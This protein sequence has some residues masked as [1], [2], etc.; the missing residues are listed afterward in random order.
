[1]PDIRGTVSILLAGLLAGWCCIAPVHARPVEL[2]TIEAVEAHVGAG[3]HAEALEGYRLLLDQA[4]G[5]E[6]L[7]IAVRLAE[8]A[9]ATGQPHLALEALE[10]HLTEAAMA[11]PELFDA[12]QELLVEAASM[13]GRQDMAISAA[14]RLVAFRRDTWGE[15]A[16][17]LQAGRLTLSGLLDQQGQHDEARALRDEAFAVLAKGDPELYLR[18]LNNTAIVL[19][20]GG[21]LDEAAQ[22]FARLIAALEEDG[23]SLSLGITH[24]NAAILDRDRRRHD[25]AIDHHRRAIEILEA[26][27]GPDSAHAIAAIGGLGQTYVF[28]GRPASAMPLLR[29]ALERARRALGDSDD[30]MLQAN[31]LA[32]VLRTLGRFAE[33]EPLDREAYGWREANL[34]P[35]HPATL[36]SRKNLA[37]DL[38]GLDRPDEAQTYYDAIVATLEGTRGPDH[39]LT[40][41]MRLERDMIAAL[42]GTAPAEGFDLDAISDRAEPSGDNVLLAN[43]LAGIAGRRG[44][45]RTE[46]ALNRLSL[47][48]ADAWHGPYHPTTLAMLTNVARS[49]SALDTEESFATYVELERRLRIWSRREFASTSD[50]ATLEQVATTT[51]ENIGDIMRYSFHALRDNPQVMQLVGRLLVEWKTPGSLE[52]AL[53]DG[54]RDRLPPEDLA[55]LERVRALRAESLSHPDAADADLAMAEAMLAERIGGLARLEGEGQRSYEAILAGLAEGEAVLDFLSVPLRSASGKVEERIFAMMAWHG[56]DAML[57]DLGLAADFEALIPPDGKL[58]TEA[59]R[60]KLHDMTVG[61]FGDRVAK[62]GRLFVVPDGVTHLIPFDGLLDGQ[63]RLLIETRDVRI[64]RNARAIPP[65][66]REQVAQPGPMLL[67]GAVDYGPDGMSALPASGPEVEAIAARMTAAGYEP[68]ILRG[69]DAGEAEVRATSG[70]RRILH[71]ATHGFFRPVEA[72]ETAPLWRA[73]I[74]LAGAGDSDEARQAADDGILYAAEV[75]SWD[76]SGVDLVVLSACDTAQGDRS[77]VEGL[78]GLPSALA[79]AGARRSL[80][81]RWPVGDRGAAIFMDRFYAHLAATSSYDEAVRRTKLDAIEGRLDVEDDTWLAFA[82]IAN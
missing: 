9:N 66:D 37:L 15:D 21:A 79:I 1:M 16:P 26:V 3:R 19:Q 77:Y 10:P 61:R 74:A 4:Q 44:D 51:R 68:E 39:P 62:V 49:E 76:L 53:L 27:A 29:D 80:L 35:A 67:V 64:L 58:M 33:A 60:R 47:R 18:M 30:T 2:P 28:A 13:T 65:A 20:D 52:R 63:G 55:L 43:R 11:A 40:R 32:A 14:R 7:Q 48:L 42:T 59:A 69:T 54:I 31:N 82:L 73:G 12:G 38:V 50:P 17:A 8:I 70:G 25:A 75:A 36:T 6:A 78:N 81:A 34:G 57:A 41:D 45:E 5:S 56:G 22:V 71:F 23:A 24:F 72:G 46:L